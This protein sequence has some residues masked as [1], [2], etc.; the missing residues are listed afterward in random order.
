MAPFFSA[1]YYT[2]QYK[3]LIAQREFS[4]SEARSLIV[5]ALMTFT[6][7]MWLATSE[8]HSYSTVKL[9]NAGSAP[10]KL[11]CKECFWLSTSSLNE[12]TREQPFH[13]PF[14]LN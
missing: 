6:T 4:G 1:K 12:L 5:P 10:L 11:A 14:A 7:S 9:V 3:D 2:N 13:H 8:E